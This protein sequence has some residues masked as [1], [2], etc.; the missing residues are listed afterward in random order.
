MKNSIF[1]LLFTLFIAGL[2]YAGQPDDK[3]VITRENAPESAK[4]RLT[5]IYPDMNAWNADLEKAESLLKELVS[6]KGTLG[7]APENLLRYYIIGDEFGKIT[8]K[9]YCMV[10]LQRSLDSRDPQVSENFQ[11]MQAFGLRTGQ[12]LSWTTPE[13]VSIPKEKAFG[14]ADK[15]IA[16]KPYRFSMENLY[17]LQDHVLSTEQEQL[18]SY[19]SGIAETPSSIYTEVAISDNKYPEFIRSNGDTVTLSRP[20]L[21]NILSFSTDRNER[22]RAYETFNANYKAREN[23]M[24]AILHSVAKSHQAYAQAYKFN[25]TLESAL[26]GPNIPVSV[27]ENL[28]KVARENP[29]PL[30]RYMK[31]RKKVLKVEDYAPWDGNMPLGTFN[32]TYTYDEAKSMISEA[33]KPLG[34]EYS[35]GIQQALNGGWIDVYEGEAKETGAYSLG[36]YGVHPYIL[37]NYDQTT[38]AVSTM[39]HELGHTMHSM[40]SAANQPYDTYQYSSFVAEVASNFNEE[41]LLDYMLKN[42]ADREERIALLDQ[43]ITNLIGSFY[44]QSQFADFELQVYRLVEQ[45]QPVNASVLTKIFHELNDAYYGP[46]VIQHPDRDLVWAQVMHFYIYPY[47]VYNYAT[48]Y[49]AASRIHQLISTGTPQQREEALQKYL[50]LLKSGGNNYPVEQLKLAG[51][52]M[53]SMEPTLAVVKRLNDLLDQLEKELNV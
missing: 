17:R 15:N 21:T 20:M 50:N 12:E 35:A 46:T 27:Y 11:R 48:S 13:L 4:W 38:D 23:T 16:F 6:M 41:L 5:D 29:D 8:G 26:N 14:W 10:S 43:A 9:L 39:A 45:G 51:V 22:Q 33:L 30:Q 18:V 49:A 52:D 53:T 19:F 3:P 2:A 28:I 42:S 32:R 7:V 24:A 36:V 34:K 47:Y 1:T 40:F 44:R 37:L 25:S 31:L